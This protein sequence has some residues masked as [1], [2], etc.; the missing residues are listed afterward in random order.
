MVQAQYRTMV[1]ATVAIIALMIGFGTI[2]V[3][4]PSITSSETGSEEPLNDSTVSTLTSTSSPTTTKRPAETDGNQVTNPTTRTVRYGSV[5]DDN[6][7]RRLSTDESKPALETAS[8]PFV[9]T[10]VLPG[11]SGRET[12]SFTNAGNETAM[13]SVGSIEISQRENGLTEPESKVDDSAGGELGSLTSGKVFFESDDSTTTYVVGGSEQVYSIESF[14]TE[15]SDV[16][17]TVAPNESVRLGV[18]WFV[19]SDTGDVIQTDSVSINMTVTAT[20]Q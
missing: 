18:E 8:V 6:S 13:V 15:R 3:E 7:V 2:G 17:V 16:S 19:P 12:V 1:T 11:D 20:T 10:D 5:P 4:D 14:S 9:V